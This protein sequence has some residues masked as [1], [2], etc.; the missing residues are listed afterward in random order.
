MSYDVEAIRERV[1]LLNLLATDGIEVKKKGARWFA[2]CPFHEEKSASFSITERTGLFT[3]FGCGA[4]KKDSG[5]KGDVF[6]YWMASRGVDFVT[7]A[8][9]LAGIAG[10]GIMPEGHRIA[11]R[12]VQST[13]LHIPPPLAGRDLEKWQEG[14]AF[15]AG[16]EEWQAKLAAWRGLSRD[17]IKI[18]CAKKRIGLPIYFQAR[19]WAFPVEPITPEGETFLAGFH[20]R[21]DA[22]KEGERAMWHYVPG[23]SDDRPSMGAW[24][25]V[26]GDPR[27]AK[28]V[29]I[30]EGEWDQ[31]ACADMLAWGINPASWVSRNVALLGVRGGRNLRTL[32]AWTWSEEAQAFLWPDN[33]AT[34]QSWIEPDGLA[35]VCRGRSRAVHTFMF[36]GAKDLNDVHRAE[37]TGSREGWLNLMRRY[38]AEGLKARRSRKP[39]FSQ[40]E[41]NTNT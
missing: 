12:A 25:M 30:L 22:K 17:T 4:G 39:K 15:L 21:L 23:S 5:I 14:V 29:M 41:P 18:L 20:V 8:A 35:S 40:H 24:P 38:Y 32:W 34:G 3:C 6:G 9:A 19:Q 7:A 37:G 28:A 26:L 2:R 16:N 1:T 36:E 13:E 31:M 33:D 10:T 11:P 27:T